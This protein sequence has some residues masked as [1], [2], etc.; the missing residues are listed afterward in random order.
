MYMCVYVCVCVCVCVYV[1]MCV[2]VCVCVRVCVCVCVC[3]YTYYSPQNHGRPSGMVGLCVC[4]CMF[5][6]Q[7]IAHIIPCGGPCWN[8]VTLPLE[9]HMLA[10]H[11]Q[12][13]PLKR[14]VLVYLPPSLIR[15]VLRTAVITFLLLNPAVDECPADAPSF[16]HYHYFYT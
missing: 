8:R 6:L 5:V 13:E 1:C 12:F 15:L 14:Y 10:W 11:V 4:V 9:Q 16:H 2:C 7:I 3:T